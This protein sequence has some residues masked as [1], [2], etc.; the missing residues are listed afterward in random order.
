MVKESP[1]RRRVCVDVPYSN[2]PSLKPVRISRTILDTPRR[3]KLLADARAYAGK[4][5]R[6]ELFKIHN[7]AERTGYHILKEGNM[8]RGP[9]VHN[10]D[11]K[12]ILTNY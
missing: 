3:S 8:R 10:R 7:V 11:R 1:R 5:P 2:P 9:E 4:M 6:K 12:R